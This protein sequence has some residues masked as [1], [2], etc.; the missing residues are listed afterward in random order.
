MHRRRPRF[1][2]WM[3]ATAAI[4]FL[5]YQVVDWVRD[6][7]GAKEIQQA[8]SELAAGDTLAA[9]ETL[10]KARYTFEIREEP[11]PAKDLLMAIYIQRGDMQQAYDVLYHMGHQ[12]HSR[13]EFFAMAKEL[14]VAALPGHRELSVDICEDFLSD[15][16]YL[17]QHEYPAELMPVLGQILRERIES[18][19]YDYRLDANRNHDWCTDSLEWWYFHGRT[20]PEQGFGTLIHLL[21]IAYPSRPDL[22]IDLLL[23]FDED[24]FQDDQVGFRGY[25]WFSGLDSAAMDRFTPEQAGMSLEKWSRYA[26]VLDFPP[27]LFYWNSLLNMRDQ[28][29]QQVLYTYLLTWVQQ[30]AREDLLTLSRDRELLRWVGGDCEG[31]RCW[32]L[33]EQW[34]DPMPRQFAQAWLVRVQEPF[35]TNE[36]QYI[37]SYEEALIFFLKAYLEDRTARLEVPG[38]TLFSS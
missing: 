38:A 20:F 1:W 14:A 7:R 6:R 21:Q 37:D 8:R 28:S 24:Y 32:A 33:Q 29:D 2:V 36:Q 23:P 9:I 34:L 35:L 3:L 22:R 13:Q 25:L 19:N 31:E 11:F 10:N 16:L 15:D 5:M 18:G 12:R 4:I 27:R 17:D 30:V 26:E